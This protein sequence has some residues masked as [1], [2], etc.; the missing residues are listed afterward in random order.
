MKSDLVL[1]Y[2]FLAFLLILF[3]MLAK[4]VLMAQEPEI[5]WDQFDKFACKNFESKELL[6]RHYML[7]CNKPSFEIY[8]D[9]KL[10]NKFLTHLESEV[11]Y[12]HCFL[13]NY[14]L[15]VA[16]G[17]LQQMCGMTIPISQ[18]CMEEGDIKDGGGGFLWKA[19]ADP[20]ARC[21]GGTTILLPASIDLQEVFILDDKK[22]I[23]FKPSYYGKL[24]D[25][26]P[27][28]CA[29]RRPGAS[30]NPGPIWLKY[31][32]KCKSIANPGVRND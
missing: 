23:I 8:T 3:I 27:R 13:N 12:Y 18:A 6:E 15:T 28:F 30:F 1:I 4:S 17:A 10:F 14:Q 21:K 24:D 32:N 9:S 16:N 2:I 26:R 11:N 25:G 22:E 7:V 20:K 29:E 5:T 19:E 31:G